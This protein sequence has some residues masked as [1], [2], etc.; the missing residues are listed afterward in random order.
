MYLPAHFAASTADA[1][2]LIRHTLWV[3]WYTSMPGG[4]TPTI[5]RGNWKPR[6]LRLHA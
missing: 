6:R 2:D 4:W 5:C 3:R 1:Y